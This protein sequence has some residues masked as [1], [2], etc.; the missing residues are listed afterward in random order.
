MIDGPT[1]SE[2]TVLVFVNG[3]HR[4]VH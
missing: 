3:D 1:N 2:V 4:R